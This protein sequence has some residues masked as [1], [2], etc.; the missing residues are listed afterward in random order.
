ML[1]PA[2]RLG[3]FLRLEAYHSHGILRG[4]ARFAREYPD[5][6]ILKLPQPESFSLAQLRALRLDGL[7]ARVTSRR[8]E[9]VLLKSGLPVVNISGQLATPQLTWVNSDDHKVG[10]MAF[11]H[12]WRRGYR[13]FAY[14]GNRTHWASL[15][16]YRSFRA[17]AFK[18]GGSLGHYVLPRREEST[19][20]PE[21]VRRDL[22]GW[23]RR[24][25]RPVGILGFNDRVAL[26]LAEACHLV[27]LAIPSQVALVGVGNDLTRLEFAPTEITSIE[28]PAFQLGYEAARAVRQLM[29]KARRPVEHLLPPPKIITRRSTDHFAVTDEIVA[30]ALDHIRENRSNTIYVEEVARVAGVSRRVLEKRFRAVL[31]MSVYAVVQR[32]HLERAQELLAN[33]ELSLSEIAYASGYENPRH[34]SLAFRRLLQ[35]TP[36]RYRSTVS[37]AETGP[38]K[39]HSPAAVTGRFDPGRANAWLTIRAGAMPI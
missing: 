33:P 35:T 21:P 17:A 28:L 8:D 24:L 11:D 6:A 3:V 20:F 23:L 29:L 1:R 10:V 32:T 26:E 22:A 14:C 18:A 31:N 2:R 19:P 25:P 4:L 30:A 39:K 37:L 7:I 27:G 34:L 13:H 5:F 12:L 16:R 15:R 38:Q 36:G 9:R